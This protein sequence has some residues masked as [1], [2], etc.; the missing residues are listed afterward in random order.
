MGDRRKHVLAV[1]CRTLARHLEQISVE[2]A[3]L[4]IG[5]FWNPICITPHFSRRK[6]VCIKTWTEENLPLP[7]TA[8]ALLH[9]LPAESNMDRSLDDSIAER[10]V[11]RDPT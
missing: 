6:T 8:R 11:W 10:Q 1:W 4:T 3:R 5:I 9:P 7:T 2:P